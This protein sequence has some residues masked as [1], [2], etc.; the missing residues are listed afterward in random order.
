MKLWS[1]WYPQNWDLNFLR[2]AYTPQN[3]P[4]QLLEYPILPSVCLSVTQKVSRFQDREVVG[5]AGGGYCGQE[6]LNSNSRVAFDHQ[7]VIIIIKIVFRCRNEKK[8][9]KMKKITKK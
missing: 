7:I 3:G 2:E 4:I 5:I 1:R 6:R 8:R 9:K